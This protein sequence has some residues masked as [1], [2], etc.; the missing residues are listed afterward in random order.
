ME[1]SPT[2]NNRSGS[3]EY[4]EGPKRVHYR[5]GSNR[6]SIPIHKS[7]SW[8]NRMG[9][10][11]SRHQEKIIKNYYQNRDAIGLQKAQE[12]I[13]ELYL[14]EGKKRATIWKRLTSH[15]EKIGMKPD[16]IE[17]LRESDDPAKV[18]EA[19]QKYA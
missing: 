14:S 6:N 15:L 11:H 5:T 2:G 10:S 16:Q 12:A 19:I 18:A 13:T 9:T 3:I 1:N 7:S 8:R 17:R 4:P